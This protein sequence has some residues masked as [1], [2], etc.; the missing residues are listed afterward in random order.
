MRQSPASP[1][2]LAMLALATTLTSG[3]LLAPSPVEAQREIA[4]KGGVAVHRCTLQQP[5]L[6]GL[7]T[8]IRIGRKPNA[9]FTP[10]G[11]RGLNREIAFSGQR[12]AAWAV[13]HFPEYFTG[14]RI[15][16]SPTCGVR[17]DP[18]DE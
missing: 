6:S 2:A 10:L 17:R 9:V 3:V 14:K 12:A 15:Y 1:P 5:G 8:G 4:P 11:E 18:D 13:E 16:Y 7:Q